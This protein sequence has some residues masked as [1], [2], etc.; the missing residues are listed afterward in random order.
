MEKSFRDLLQQKLDESKAEDKF[1][2]TIQMFEGAW[3]G[4]HMAS[5][6]DFSAPVDT[7]RYRKRNCLDIGKKITELPQGK[8]FFKKIEKLFE[9][10]NK[11]VNQNPC[12]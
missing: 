6:D 4:L 9:E 3:Q 10:R 7:L 5:R 2:E 11:M 8:E 12:I 1:T